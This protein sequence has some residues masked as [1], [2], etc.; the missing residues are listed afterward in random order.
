[1]SVN[2]PLLA[3]VTVPVPVAIGSLNRS[4]RL[5]HPP[6][7]R[8]FRLPRASPVAGSSVS[9]PASDSNLRR[10]RV[11]RSK[12]CRVFVP[13]TFRDAPPFETPV[14]SRLNASAPTVIP[15]ADS[16][17]KACPARDGNVPPPVVPGRRIVGG[18]SPRRH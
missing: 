18:R 11:A 8:T 15:L 12:A 13:P 14:P 17:S 5:R 16:N 7:T 2:V 4:L 6:S 10:R 3:F 1:V 9:V